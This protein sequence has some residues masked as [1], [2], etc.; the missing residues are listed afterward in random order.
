MS[1]SICA[2][3]DDESILY[4]LEAMAR[5]Q[6]WNFRGTTDIDECLAWAADGIVEMLL[7]DFHMPGRNGL[8][9]LRAVKAINPSLPV[10]VLTVEQNPETAEALLMEGAEDFINKPVRLADFLSRIRLH[11]RLRE[12]TADRRGET[13]KGIAPARLQQVVA[14]LKESGD[15]AETDAVAA[16]CG[17]SY[18]TAHRYL[19]HLVKSG[20]AVAVEVQQEGRPGR[21]SRKYRFT[22]MARSS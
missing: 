12:Q 16:V 1:L 3:D 15:G 20:L 17:L 6:N 2:L 4:T 5:T 18:T 7:L 14:F 13:R 11:K 8:D 9:V 10:L 19:D 22:G 21:P